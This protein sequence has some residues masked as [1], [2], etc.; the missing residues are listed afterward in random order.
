M[1]K[2]STQQGFTLIEL[3]MVIVILGILAAVALPKFADMGKNARLASLQGALAAVKTA[4]DIVHSQA[5]VENKA[6]AT[7]SGAEVTMERGV[8]VDLVFGYPAESAISVAAGLS[9]S[10][11]D[12]DTSGPVVISPKGAT[13]PTNC[14]FTYTEAASAITAPTISAIAGSGSGC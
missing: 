7:G 2:R 12:I 5:L 10:D 14:K 11:Y 13:D 4:S 9:T 1:M 8:T 6:T 3:V